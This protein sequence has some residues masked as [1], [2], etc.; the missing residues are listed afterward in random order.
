VK[1]QSTLSEAG[2]PKH[3]PRYWRGTRA[4]FLVFLPLAYSLVA[5]PSFA[6]TVARVIDG[7][8]IVLADGRKVRYLGVN[9]PER[10]QPFAE[11]ARRY[12]ERLVLHKEVRL[13][14]SRQ[15]ADTYGRVLAYVYVDDV[16][17]NA[18]LLAEGLGHLFVL[19]TLEPYEEWLQLQKAAR[20]QRKGMW[21]AGGVS[22][23][24]KITTVQADAKGDDRRN[25][26][27]EY[28]RIC[29]VS[30]SAVALRGFSIQDASHHRYVFP[31]GV[32]APG[33]TAVLRSGRGQDTIRRGQLVFYWG[34]G[35]I[36]NNDGDTAS[37]FTPNGK[38]IDVFPV[39]GKRRK[40]AEGKSRLRERRLLFGV[41]VKG[42]SVDASLG[43]EVVS[44]H[45]YGRSLVLHEDNC[46]DQ[47]GSRRI[48][49][50][51]RP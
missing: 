15:S 7:D 36:W 20:A 6:A 24:L 47:T 21:Q 11:E 18:R 22:S 48:S 26:G 49:D 40:R 31:S 30:D 8:T 1:K 4:F 10:G 42:A 43:S 29:N 33:Y 19:D 45:T 9:T 39:Q 32:L 51:A 3:R 2:G 23:P 12:N 35:P 44:C 37:L 41:T 38:L 25:P 50:E 34:F 13:E 14:I 17:V 16:L 5:L 27:G 46:T 28:L